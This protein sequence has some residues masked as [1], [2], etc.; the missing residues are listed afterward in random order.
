MANRSYTSNLI[1]NIQHICA[2]KNIERPFTF[3][4]KQG[5]THGIATRLLNNKITEINLAHIEKLCLI[6]NC[7]PN[8]LFDYKPTQ[9]VE[10]IKNNPLT[11]IIKSQQPVNFNELVRSL[12][13]DKLKE[14]EEEIRKRK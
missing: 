7:T 6:F 2:V 4:R 5:F 3:L 8:E 14:I 1:L 13:L 11:A 12:P 10:Q 9:P